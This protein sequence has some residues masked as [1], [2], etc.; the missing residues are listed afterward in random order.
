M[1]TSGQD[2]DVDVECAIGLDG[3][4]VPAGKPQAV[5]N[6]RRSHQSVIDRSAGDADRL[7]PG[8]QRGARLDAEEPG[9]RKVPGLVGGIRQLFDTI[10]ERAARQHGRITWRQLRAAGVDTDRIG[11]WSAD[12]RLRRV[13]HGVY[14]VGH[15]APS[16]HAELMA[17][18]LACGEGARASHHSGGHLFGILRFRPIKPH[19]TVP[20]TAG[21][22]RPG[23]LVHRVRELLRRRVRAWRSDGRGGR[24]NAG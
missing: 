20:T 4:A 22:T 19:V 14:A 9:V 10:A 8:Q 3:S 12:G 15:T 17:A 6:S 13:H 5:L 16:P 23:I 1:T 24:G 21:R 2:L 11:R 18:V 7:E